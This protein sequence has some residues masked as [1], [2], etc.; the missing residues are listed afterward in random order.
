MTNFSS[1]V[2]FP[3]RQIINSY[4]IFLFN[5]IFI[6]WRHAKV[7]VDKLK[8]V[9]EEAICD[10]LVQRIQRLRSAGLCNMWMET[11]ENE[12]YSASK[13][14]G[15]PDEEWEFIKNYS[16]LW[17]NKGRIKTVDIWNRLFKR[18][19]SKRYN[20]HKREISIQSVWCKFIDSDSNDKC[21]Y[22]DS[23]YFN[24]VDFSSTRISPSIKQ[25]INTIEQFGEN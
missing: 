24:I 20:Y 13:I 3:W 1:K 23:N 11:D 5:L 15:Y 2:K 16:G 9:R 22:F 12:W 10:M 18:I 4:N 6:F 14:L 25:M 21:N 8:T 7:E 19:V 17:Y